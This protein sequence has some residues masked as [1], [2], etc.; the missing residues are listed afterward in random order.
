MTSPVVGLAP[1]H[2]C[3]VSGSAADYQ[4][5]SSARFSLESEIIPNQRQCFPFPNYLLGRS[6][7]EFL[8]KLIDLKM[9]LLAL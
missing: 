8:T 1:S 5:T 7:K 6:G 4:M 3:R 2:A 9:A